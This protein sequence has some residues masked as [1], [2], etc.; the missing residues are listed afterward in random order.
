M[1]GNVFLSNIK[2]EGLNVTGIRSIQGKLILIQ[3]QDC[4]ITYKDETLFSPEDGIFSMVVGRDITSAFAG[5]ADYNSFP[6]LYEVSKTKTV[7]IEKTQ[8][9]NSLELLYSEVREMR[10][11]GSLIEHRLEEIFETIENRY[12]KE[13]LLALEL[14]ELTTTEELKTEL[15]RFLTN[16]SSEYP[17]LRNLINDGLSLIL[18]EN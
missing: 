7:K 17:K 16:L 15:V 18:E 11:R 12:P 5:A 10:E 2:V 9:I 3:L 13:W 1:M 14:L 6:N 4:T 8:E